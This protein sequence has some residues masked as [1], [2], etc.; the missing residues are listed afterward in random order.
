MKT[1]DVSAARKAGAGEA[2]I[3][4]FMAQN[5]L[6]PKKTVGGFVGNI[7]KSGGDL[8][9]GTVG[10]VA[11]IFNPDMQKNTVANVGK[12]ALGAGQ[13]LVPGEQGYEENARNVGRFYKDRYG[14]FENIGDTLYND[15]VGA[16]ADISTLLSGGGAALR[17]AGA[18]SKASGLASA[19]KTLSSIGT[20]VDPLMAAGR[21][22]SNG[23]GKAAGRLAPRLNAAADRAAT[24]GIGNPVAQAKM[25]K[26]AGR[27][28]PSF[29][30]EYDLYDRSP[31]AAAQ[32]TKNI[33]SQYDDLALKSGKQLPMGQIV[34]SFDAEIERLSQGVGGVVSDS[35][36]AKIIELI[37]RR[38]QLIQAAGGTVDA[39]GELNSAPISTGVDTLTNFRRKVIDPDVPQSMFGLDAQGSGAA[40]GV[41]RS[42]DIVKAGIDSSD[43]RLSKLG[44]DFGMAKGMEDI[45]EKSSARQGNRQ[46]VNFSK[47]GTAGIGGVL[48]G[49]PGAI[50]GA[51]VEQTVNSPQFL[52]ATSKTLRATAEATND[53]RMG[54]ILSNGM[55][56]AGTGYEAARNVSRINPQRTTTT[57]TERR[58]PQHL[59][60]SP[61]SYNPKKRSNFSNAVSQRMGVNY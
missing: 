54:R 32:V 29:I 16:A 5:G 18:I 24:A 35:D 60:E 41:K 47:L 22:V 17:G 21:V 36:K 4:Q 38:D 50:G 20:K 45:L 11:N 48:G 37:K 52:K 15:P 23:I 12:L 55:N 59:I 39:M 6:K 13:L 9:G 43:P 26:K 2:Q 14:S 8:V 44:R 61:Q 19:G 25:A 31:E 53:P 34:K 28:V 3:Q 40:Q 58:L 1:F 33:G 30:D 10:A 27:S 46:V 42:R 56:A 49:V 7:F 51:M 57:E